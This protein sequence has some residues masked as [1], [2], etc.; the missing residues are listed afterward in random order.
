VT[1]KRIDEV[2]G[3]IK[4]ACLQKTG[5]RGPAPVDIAVSL[6]VGACDLVRLPGSPARASP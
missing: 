3:W 5:F 2:L 4:T 1:R 6:A